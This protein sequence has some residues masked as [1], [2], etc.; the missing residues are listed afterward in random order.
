VIAGDPIALRQLFVILLTNAMSYTP[1]GGHIWLQGHTGSGSQIQVSVRDTG[2]G[3]AVSDLP[4]LFTRFYRADKA[5]SRHGATTAE[6]APVGV[7]LGLAI[8]HSIVEQHGGSIT[9]SSP[10]EGQGSTFTVFLK[11]VQTNSP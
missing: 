4:H 8:A 3:I 11:R 1:A 10:G 7:G 9:V 6:H 5:R 2:S